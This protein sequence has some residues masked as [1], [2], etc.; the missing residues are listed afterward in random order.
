MSDDETRPSPTRRRQLH[1][2]TGRT[3]THT[4]VRDSRFAWIDVGDSWVEHAGIRNLKL[5]GVEIEDVEISGELNNV[6][7]NG[8]DIGPLVEA[9]LGR[10]DPAYLK[11]NPQTADEYRE[12]WEVVVRRWAETVSRARALDPELLHERV[13]GEWSFIETLRHLCYATDAWVNRVYLG[14]ADPWSPL[15]LPFDT[16]LGLEWGHDKDI[17]PT[18]DEVL[19]VRNDRQET[20]RR[21]LAT[22]TD[23]DL[24]METTPVEGAGW[25][26]ADRYPVAEALG[27]PINEEWWHRTY[28]ERDLAVLEARLTGS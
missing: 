2:V 13:E 22:L 5:R 1:E 6:T 7:V 9:E 26:P 27:I 14:D 17:H 15:D 11:L 16:L 8:V 10:R 3:W 25:P 21:V 19:E 23:D 4:R 28:A 12:A 20:V 18:L 24:A